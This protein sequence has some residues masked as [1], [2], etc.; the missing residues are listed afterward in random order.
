M[1]TDVPT[2]RDEEAPLST[3]AASVGDKSLAEPPL[4]AYGAAETVAAARADVG[5]RL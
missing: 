4:S 1:T 3:C 2:V 5:A